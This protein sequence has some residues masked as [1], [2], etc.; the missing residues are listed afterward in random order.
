[1]DIIESIRQEVIERNKDHIEED[2]FDM[3]DDHIRYVVKNA[4]ELAE[5]FHADKEIVELGALLHDI[6]II[7]DDG[8]IEEHHINGAEIAVALL[9]KY[10]YP[11]ERIERVRRCILN[12]RGSKE[13]LRNTIEE[14]II[15]DADVIAHFDSIP[16]LFSDAFH[17]LGFNVKEGTDFVKKKLERDYSKLSPR[18]KELLEKR[19][20]NMMSILFLEEYPKKNKKTQIF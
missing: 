13:F 10:H 7:T 15:A 19:Y 6:A 2:R 8:E 4:L 3:Y 17:K 20:Q 5:K 9:R 12:H 1:M 18:T 11:E 14:E 16:S